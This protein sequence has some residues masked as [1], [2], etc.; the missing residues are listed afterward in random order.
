M[1]KFQ[2]K[3]DGA[4]IAKTSIV[5]DRS[6]YCST[7]FLLIMYDL[8][9]QLNYSLDKFKENLYCIQGTSLIINNF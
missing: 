6:G 9:I 1:I 5:K 2:I 7:F 8:P 4:K 3:L